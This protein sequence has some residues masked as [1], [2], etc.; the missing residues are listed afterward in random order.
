MSYNSWGPY[1]IPAHY[2]SC[3]EHPLHKIA[4]TLVKLELCNE[5]HNIMMFLSAMTACSVDIMS[6]IFSGATDGN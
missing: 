6:R 2:K 3:E 1:T 5:N 4:E